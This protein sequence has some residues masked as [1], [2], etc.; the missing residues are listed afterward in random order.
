MSLNEKSPTFAGRSSGGEQMPNSEE[1]K[2][3]SYYWIYGIMVKF[4]S[5]TYDLIRLFMIDKKK[6]HIAAGVICDKQNNVFITQR[7]LTSHMGGYWEF[8]GGKLEDKETPEQ[9]L[10]RELQEEIGINVTQ[11]QL[12]ETVEHDFIDRH[13]TLSFFL[14]TEWENKPYGKEGQLS[15]WIPIMSLNAEDFPPA[16]RSIVA[17][18]QK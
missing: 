16:N 5:E 17:L 18:L 9:A 11:C 3:T 14:V 6:L 13:I 12:L 7:P 1:R 2:S 10:Y 15:R 4:V 8:P